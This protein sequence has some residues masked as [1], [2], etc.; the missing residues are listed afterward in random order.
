MTSTI[1]TRIQQ[2]SAKNAELLRIL[3]ETDHA[4][5]ALGQQQRLIRDLEAEVVASDKRLANADRKRKKELREHEQ[6]RDSVLRRFAYKA[7]GQREKFESKAQKEET[8]YFE[9]LQEEHRETE[10]NK[11]LKAQL[12]SARLVARDLEREVGRHNQAQSELDALYDAIFSGTTPEFPREDELEQRLSLAKQAYH[13]ARGRAEAENHALKLLREGQGRMRSA[14]QC[15]E[16]A[17][18]AS[19]GDMFTDGGFADAMERNALH[20]AESEVMT[21]RMLVLQAQRMSP[22]VRDLPEVRID[23]GNVVRDIFFD[24]I[25]TDYAFHQ[26]IKESRESVR[27]CAAAMDGLE[28]EAQ[29]RFH[30]TED[31]RKRKEAEMHAARVALQRERGSA[32]EAVA[33]A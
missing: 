29:V 15:M 28:A 9:S 33:K 6:Y 18:T 17:L 31:E 7:T 3:A 8:E 10:I 21:A 27:R 30:Q 1:T 23:Q 32:F 4:I 24:N 14:L 20:R 22:A 19:R 25:F 16:Q 12:E 11:N 2:A 5:P 13:D 26:K